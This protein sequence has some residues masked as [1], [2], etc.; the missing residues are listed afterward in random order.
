MPSIFIKSGEFN[1][2]IFSLY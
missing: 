1:L 2:E